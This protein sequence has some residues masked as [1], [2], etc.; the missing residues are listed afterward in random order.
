MRV[1]ITGSNGFLGS[2]LISLIQKKHP[3]WEIFGIDIVPAFNTKI[4]FSKL[5]LAQN[6]NWNIVL[7]KIEPNVI[8]HLA[9]VFKISNINLMLKINTNQFASIIDAINSL[10]ITPVL[11]V[12]GSAAEYGIVNHEDN[13]ITETHPLIPSSFYGLTKKW[14]EEIALFYHRTYETPVICTRPSNFIGKGISDSLLPGYLASRFNCSENNIKIEISS[15]EDRRDYIDV[16]DACEAILE[17]AIN[18]NTI[19]EVFNISQGRS[20]SNIELIELFEQASKKKAITELQN[21]N[22][23]FDIYLSNDKIKEFINWEPHLSIKK[24][25]EWC[26]TNFSKQS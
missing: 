4:N 22:S 8:F 18:K 5:D 23:Y 15:H 17:L 24:S 26:L 6:V 11:V 1:L 13:P 19:G 14:Q 7:K 2:N 10:A 25:I 3:K 9:G 21:R 20:I 12:I 16:R